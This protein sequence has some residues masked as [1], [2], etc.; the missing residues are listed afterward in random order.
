[1]YWQKACARQEREMSE[2]RPLGPNRTNL[3]KELTYYTRANNKRFDD[4][5][6]LQQR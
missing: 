1:M 3:K 2:S 5:L 4:V 6:M